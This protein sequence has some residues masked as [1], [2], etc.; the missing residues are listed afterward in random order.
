MPFDP[1]DISAPAL[2][3][4]LSHSATCF[5]DEDDKG[6]LHET[7]SGVLIDASPEKVRAVITDYARYREW[8]PQLTKSEV[9]GHKSG[10]TDVAFSLG[11]RFALFSR[12]IDYSLR[13]RE[14][15]EKV[16]WEQV[17]GDFPENRGS[18]HWIPLERGKKTAAF[19]AFYVDLAGLGSMVKM[20]LKASP[21]MEVAIS[22]STAV[23]M[24]RALKARV[25]ETT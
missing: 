8:A 17:S 12:S 7:T 22:T 1:S 21:Q 9:L 11:F 10:A 2:A 3:S 18:W 16:A 24:A 23:L 25:E 14:K 15:G 13:Y 19:Y 5:V 6:R 20:A 4:I